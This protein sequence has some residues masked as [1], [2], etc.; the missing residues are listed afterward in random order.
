MTPLPFLQAEQ[1]RSGRSV[2][3][4]GS[5]TFTDPSLPRAELPSVHL[6]VDAIARAAL[7]Q[8]FPEPDDLS[9]LHV[10]IRRFPTRLEIVLRLVDRDG[11]CLERRRVIPRMRLQVEQVHIDAF[12]SSAAANAGLV[13][14]V[15]QIEV[16]GTGPDAYPRT[17]YLAPNQVRVT[18]D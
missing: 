5:A 16:S 9:E 14:L 13:F 3:F 17:L 12:L 15:S 11:G 2:V 6:K 7:I 1:R 4:L 8:Q 18:T 10:A